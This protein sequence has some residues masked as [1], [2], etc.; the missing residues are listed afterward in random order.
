MP[1]RH[2]ADKTVI[3]LFLKHGQDK[4]HQQ[5]M[6][7]IKNILAKNFGN[8]RKPAKFDKIVKVK[9]SRL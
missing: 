1:T 6:I 7:G 5:S 2:P 8:S 3:I 9:K 4:Q